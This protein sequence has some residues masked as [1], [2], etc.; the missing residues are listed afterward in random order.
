MQILHW[1]WKK[2]SGEQCDDGNA[3]DN[4]SFDTNFKD[5]GNFRAFNEDN[6]NCKWQKRISLEGHIYWVCIPIGIE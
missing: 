3:N 5:T 2:E 6:I 1:E 4:A